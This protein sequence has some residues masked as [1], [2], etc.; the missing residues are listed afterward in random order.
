M[1]DNWEVEFRA[2]WCLHYI[3]IQLSVRS[4][5][6][7][8]SSNY[9]LLSCH[10]RFNAGDRKS[11]WVSNA[12]DLPGSR[13][14]LLLPFL[15]NA[16]FRY[17][18]LW[19]NPLVRPLLNVA[20]SSCLV[21]LSFVCSKESFCADVT[22]L[23]HSEKLMITKLISTENYSLHMILSVHPW[24]C[25]W[26]ALSFVTTSEVLCWY[27]TLQQLYHIQ[28]VLNFLKQPFSNF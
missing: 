21:L 2:S 9:V 26:K 25:G 23:D 6:K 11:I 7:H 8:D 17:R 20:V 12:N 16:K 22:S 14:I 3:W 19:D 15:F 1:N 13:D 24:Q 10:L 27:I 28:T 5:W 4:K 18:V